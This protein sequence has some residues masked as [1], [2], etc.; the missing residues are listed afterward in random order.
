MSLKRLPHTACGRGKRVKIIL[1]D[2]TELVDRFLDRTDRWVLL[3]ERGRVDK[4]D[5]RA[6]FIFKGEA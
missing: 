6:F 2:G 3:K 1:R 5:I 4:R